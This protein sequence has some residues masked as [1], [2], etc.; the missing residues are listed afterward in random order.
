MVIKST[1]YDHSLVVDQYY[2][3]DLSYQ[4]H[5]DKL[6]NNQSLTANIGIQLSDDGQHVEFEFP[7]QGQGVGGKILFFRPSDKSRDF[8]IPIQL[9]GKKH[10]YFSTKDLLP[11]LWK[12][13]IDWYLNGIAYYK[14]QSIVL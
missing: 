8:E 2:E 3:K 13:K 9:N 5:Y 4:D 10:I 14:E 1:Q 7:Q 11:G 12:I 6:N